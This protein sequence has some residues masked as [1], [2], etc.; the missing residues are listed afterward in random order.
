[1]PKLPGIHHRRAVAAFERAGFEV[2]RER[3][4]IIMTDGKRTIAIPRH[5]PVNAI[6]M[7]AIVRDAGMTID[8]FRDLL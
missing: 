3:K 5:D 1:M 7:A 4:H 2:A 6:T 8:E